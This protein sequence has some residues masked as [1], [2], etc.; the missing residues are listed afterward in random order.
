MTILPLDISVPC[1]LSMFQDTWYD[2][3][4]WCPD[5]VSGIPSMEER[6]AIKAAKVMEAERKEKEEEKENS[7]D[8]ASDGVD[9]SLRDDISFYPS[10]SPSNEPS[11][12]ISFYPSRAPSNAPTEALFRPSSPTDGD[13]VE[14][15]NVDNV[16]GSEQDQLLFD[17]NTG[18][19]V[20]M[21]DNFSLQQ[22]VLC[23]FGAFMMGTLMMYC[24]F[25]GRK[26]LEYEEL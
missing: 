21:N 26:Q 12:D 23:T 18:F 11:K 1:R 5:L 8:L 22:L 10:R 24:W 14:K 15:E 25:S 16:I 7:K 9:G 13:V 4:V 2:D 6:A 20:R 17:A 3:R 19:N